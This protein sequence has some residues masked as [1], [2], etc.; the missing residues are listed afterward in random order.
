MHYF[1]VF[2]DGAERAF[3]VFSGANPVA[4]N[5]FLVVGPSGETSLPSG[6][7]LLTTDMIVD[8]GHGGEVPP[9]N[10]SLGD[11]PTNDRQ[12]RKISWD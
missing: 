3:R 12:G 4:A 7:V 5:R 9:I 10:R 1:Q 2:Q 6:N 8:M 11:G